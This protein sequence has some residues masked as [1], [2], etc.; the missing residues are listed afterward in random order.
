V[1]LT[2]PMERVL[3]AFLEDTH[4]RRYGYDLMRAVSLKS[5]TLYPMLTRLET[6]GLVEARW[7]SAGETPAGRPAR[8]Y[9]Q[10][11]GEGVQVARQV[12]AEASFAEFN[13]GRSRL[14]S[15]IP[16]GQSA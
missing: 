12:L 2:K 5:G 9:Y 14:G 16:G 7:E 1:K 10:L 15:A 13:R 6:E 3:R 4:A 8:R 11:T